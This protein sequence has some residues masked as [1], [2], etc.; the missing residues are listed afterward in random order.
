MGGIELIAAE[1]RRQIEEEGWMPGHDDEHTDGEMAQAAVC[2]AAPE[3]VYVQRAS[4]NQVRFVDPWPWW[5][6]WDKRPRNGNVVLAN[7]PENVSPDERIRQLVMSGALI[8]AEIDRLQ[9]AK[10]KVA[11]EQVG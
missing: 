5:P 7:N 3:L 9:R 2:Y 8:A 4:A 10:A 11:S 1:R 6:K